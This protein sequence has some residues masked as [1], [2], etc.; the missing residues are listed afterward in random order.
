MAKKKD[1][2]VVKH[3]RLVE[4]SY[5]LSLIEQQV[6]LFAI[7]RCREEQRGLF[8]DMPVTIRAVDFATQFGLNTEDGNVY[9]QLKDAMDTLFSR[10]VIIHDTDP[11]T[12]KPRVTK[13][14]WISQA[15]GLSNIIY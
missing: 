2:L 11:K 9:R 10:H 1:E 8:A 6:V 15:R 7:C 4:A 13:S 3:N 12:E 14:R 5:R